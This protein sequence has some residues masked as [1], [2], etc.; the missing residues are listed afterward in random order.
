MIVHVSSCNL[1][2]ISNFL[3]VQSFDRHRK[4]LEG[5]ADMSKLNFNLDCS[6]SLISNGAKC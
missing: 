4:I 3:R 6:L 1:L 2:A 5:D